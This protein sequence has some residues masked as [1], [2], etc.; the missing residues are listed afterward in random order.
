MPKWAKI[1][2]TGAIISVAV[3]YF[4]RPSLDKL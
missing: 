2:L 3:D 4:L 1:A